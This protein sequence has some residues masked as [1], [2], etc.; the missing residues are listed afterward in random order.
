MSRVGKAVGQRRIPTGY[1]EDTSSVGKGY[2]PGVYVGVVKDNKDPQKFGRLRVYIS[3]F[4]GDPDEEGNWISVS[5]ASPFAG[6]TS[7]YDQ[8]ANVTE[9]SDTIKSY[10]F[11]ATPPDLESYV[12]VAFSAGRIELG[13]WFA[14]LFQRGTQVSIPGIPYGNTHSGSDK[15]VAPK[16]RK[17]PDP[18][19]EKYVE[20]KPI[21][22]ALKKQGLEKDKLRG[23][24]TSSAMRESPSR[25]IGLLTPGQ[26]QFVLD[27]GSVDGKDRLIRLRTTNGTQILLDDVAGHIYLISKNGENWLEL[28]A[29]GNVHLYGT[30]DVNVHS[31]KNIN[32][33]ADK[34]INL[35]AGNAINLKA[36]VSDVQIE[37]GTDIN[38]LAGSTTRITSV[39]TSNINS[40]V[41]HYETAGVIHM[42]GPEAEMTV[43]LDP[44]LLVVNQAITQSICSTVP[45]H[46]PWRGHSGSINPVGPGNQQMQKD[47]A[48]EQQ[49]RQPSDEEQG[50]PVNS[51]D[52][53]ESA[54][55]SEI[56][57][58]PEGAQA[59]KEFNGYSPVNVEDGNGQSGGYGSNI[60][61][62]EQNVAQTVSNDFAGLA[63]NTNIKGSQDIGG[64]LRG[65]ELG[66]PKTG[67]Q[68]SLDAKT[69][70]RFESYMAQAASALAAGSGAKGSNFGTG[71]GSVAGQNFSQNSLMGILSEGISPS[72]AESMFQGDLTKNEQAVKRTLSVNGVTS[73]P[74]NVFDGL[75]S[76]QNQT[77]NINYAYINGEKIDLSQT[78]K[79]EDWN[80]L[81][82]FIA[83][84]DRDRPRRIQEAAMIAGN[85]Y[86]R[87]ASDEAIINAGYANAIGSLS[88][89]KLNQQ[90]GSPATDQQLVAV[91]S[92][93]FLETGNTL[94]NQSFRFSKMV[95]TPEIKDALVKQAGPFPY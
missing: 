93:Y 28:S 19:L 78:Y 76:Y 20:H 41:G 35:E 57:T 12:L 46:E 59:I 1:S 92:S 74:Q 83:A 71:N 72:R 22:Y 11:W 23:I 4:G 39:E 36:N 25:V 63:G 26:H 44:Y 51:Q 80:R 69:F 58:S 45:E 88:K 10:G 49:P 94:P 67:D 18:D 89:G 85:S 70:D 60:I 17:D 82:G 5:Y 24:T 13:F 21:S 75:V 9:Y 81:A 43:A 47:P 33:Y 79:A 65:F 77:G 55:V 90:S 95:A 52:K 50:S 27:D 14:C 3:E 64:K 42:N 7:I 16:N 56:T 61:E 40:G 48:P 84:D 32:L 31:E 62:P 15:P 91:A 30:G 29:D 34:D 54:P 38:T 53:E 66:L 6:T 87:P 2:S 68:V 86:G 37:A 73:V 8:G